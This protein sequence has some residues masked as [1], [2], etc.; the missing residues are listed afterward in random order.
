MERRAITIAYQLKDNR[1]ELSGMAEGLK[2]FVQTFDRVI[3]GIEWK[4]KEIV[5]MAGQR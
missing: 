3:P 5:P 4:Q 1:V 2:V